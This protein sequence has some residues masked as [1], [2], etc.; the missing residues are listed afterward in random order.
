MVY[1]GDDIM[2]AYI[3]L[4]DLY[5][6]NE[7][8]P[9]S[10]FE[11]KMQVSKRTIQNEISYLK[12]HGKKHGFGIESA[13]NKGYFLSVENVHKLETYLDSLRND[14][15]VD[16]EENLI[17][18]IISQLLESDEYITVTDISEKLRVSRRGC[19]IIC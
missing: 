9:L 4:R 5:Y 13:Y 11:E 7:V 8:L 3:I 12:K 17:L 2:R 1:E 6:S 14:R 16:T 15:D 18:S 19:P 10:Y